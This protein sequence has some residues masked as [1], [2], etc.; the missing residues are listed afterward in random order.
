MS[1]EYDRSSV[2]SV[3]LFRRGENNLYRRDLRMNYASVSLRTYA[4]M[5]YLHFVFGD[6]EPISMNISQGTIV[7]TGRA[8]KDQKNLIRD[9]LKASRMPVDRKA[10]AMNSLLLDSR[11]GMSIISDPIYVPEKEIS[12]HAILKWFE[13][14]QGECKRKDPSELLEE[15]D[16]EGDGYRCE[17]F[18]VPFIVARDGIWSLCA[19][20]GEN[21]EEES[22]REFEYR[23]HGD[24]ELCDFILGELKRRNVIGGD[25]PTRPVRRDGRPAAVVVQ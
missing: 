20:H 2:Y 8:T 14:K 13:E 23:E 9:F 22:H 17:L 16:E 11:S 21:D 12:C 1:L 6:H 24:S 5:H 3:E 19:P 18:G 15:L 10:K 4:A 7:S 25:P